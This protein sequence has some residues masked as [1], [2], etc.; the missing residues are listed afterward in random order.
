MLNGYAS[1]RALGRDQPQT[2]D[3]F[4]IRWAHYSA[5]GEMAVYIA[6][7]SIPDSRLVRDDSHTQ[8]DNFLPDKREK[9]GNKASMQF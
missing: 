1:H 9:R 2:N 5:S 6:E 8:L 7:Q 3:N 4:P